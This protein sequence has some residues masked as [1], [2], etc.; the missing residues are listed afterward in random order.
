MLIQPINTPVGPRGAETQAYDCEYDKLW[1]RF[2]LEEMKYLLFSFIG[3][4]VEAHNGI[5]FRHSTR[6]ASLPP[7]TENGERMS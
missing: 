6:N 7:S 4:S 5:K 1:I 3:S 2:P